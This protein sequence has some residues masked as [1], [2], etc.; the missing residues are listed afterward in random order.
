[1]GALRI[2]T[3][4]AAAAAIIMTGATL[5]RAQEVQLPGQ[6]PTQTPPPPT[7]EKEMQAIEKP[8]KQLGRY[9]KDATK[10]Q[11]S[12]S[13]IADMEQHTLVAKGMTPKIPKS[14]PED[15]HA[16]YLSDYRAM[17]VNMVREELD[18]EEAL[19]EGKNDKAAESIKALHDIEEQGHKE[20]KPKEKH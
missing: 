2:W 9:V 11:R 3:L 17:M 5:A 6:I 20:F 16:K 13:L 7:L 1:M 14:V 18:L 19:I 8:Y 15:Q 4:S 12:L 10:N